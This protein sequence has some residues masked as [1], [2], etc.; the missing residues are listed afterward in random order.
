MKTFRLTNSDFKHLNSVDEINSIKNGKYKNIGVERNAKEQITF[1]KNKMHVLLELLKID[2]EYNYKFEIGL[3][4]IRI[5]TQ[6]GGIPGKYRDHMWIWMVDKNEYLKLKLKGKQSPQLL[7][8]QIQI[9]INQN[10]F[11]SAEIWFEHK[12]LYQWR[13]KIS[14]FFEVNNKN[15][16]KLEF[17]L[18]NSKFEKK[19]F[20]EFGTAKNIDEFINALNSRNDLKGGIGKVYS[21]NEILRI[22]NSYPLIKN[23]LKKIIDGLYKEIVGY[24]NLRKTLNKSVKFRNKKAT[25]INILKKIFRK[26]TKGGEVKQI[27]RK[28]QKRYVKYLEKKYGKINVLPEK[29]FIDIRVNNGKEIR[30]YELKTS[31]SAYICIRQAL[32]QLLFYSWR[33]KNEEIGKKIK[34]FV[35]GINDLEEN[36]KEFYDYVKSS[37]GIELEYIKFPFKL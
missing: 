29:D 1:V 7:L 20:D 36:I 37:I 18:F 33:V 19:E 35:I 24:K 22:K 13:E 32:G 16:N 28:M 3:S 17:Y 5:R 8:P 10:S 21:K 12:A 27:H 6:K 11:T 4:R 23:D 15:F 9:S 30:I 25:T 31:D 14:A 34:L 2:P 26:G